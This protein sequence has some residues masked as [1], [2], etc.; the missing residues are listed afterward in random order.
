LIR[1]RDSRLKI[2]DGLPAFARRAVNCSLATKPKPSLLKGGVL[3][4]TPP[5]VKK[6]IPWHGYL[7]IAPALLSLIAFIVIPAV[8][9]AYLSLQEYVMPKPMTF[10]GFDNFTRI[11]QDKLFFKSLFN[12]GRYTLGSMVL[13]LSAALGMA[14]LL[15]RELKGMRVYRVMY[16]LPTVVSEVITALIFLW[17]LDS[18][19]G[20]FNHLLRKWG[21]TPVPWLMTEKWAMFSVILLGSWR[22]ASYNTPIFLAALRSIPK[23]LYEAADIDGAH[24]WAKFRHISV[25]MIMPIVVYCMVMA[26]IGS[27]QVIGIIDVMT[28]GG[29]NNSTYVTLKYIWR[30]AFEFN[31]MGYAAALS[32]TVFPIL[33][34]VTWLQ[35]KLAPER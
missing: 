34:C 4:V 12:T 33:L 19:L 2:E 6:P 5:V 28:D 31:N 13:G 9:L 11:A 24:G 35:M 3:T 15:N 32:F 26:A 30:Q 23:D 20:L 18:E 27:F 17:M 22:G 14:V 21:Y 29:P 8:Y 16:F 10:I 25:P 7:F 1:R